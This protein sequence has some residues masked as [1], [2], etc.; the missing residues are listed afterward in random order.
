MARKAWQGI[1]RISRGLGWKATVGT[2]LIPCFTQSKHYSVDSS[3]NQNR[4]SAA[5]YTNGFTYSI[6]IGMPIGHVT[7]ENAISI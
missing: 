2:P 4:S 1:P 6:A 3:M 5:L 7:R